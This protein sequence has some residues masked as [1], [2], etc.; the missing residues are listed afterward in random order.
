[1]LPEEIDVGSGKVLSAT[2]SLRPE[3]ADAA[4]NHWIL[5]GGEEW[6]LVIRDHYLAMKRWNR[7]RYGYADLADVTA[8]PKVQKNSCPGYWWSEQMKYYY[9]AFADCPRV[10]YR[11]LYLST[12]REY[13][14]WLTPRLTLTPPPRPPPPG[15]PPPAG[16]TSRRRG[17]LREQL[18]VRAAFDDPALV[19]H[20]DLV[21]IDDG[22]EAVGDD[23]RRAA[24]RD[25]VERL[26]DRRLGAAV[27]RAGRFVEDQDRRVLE[28]GAGD[29]DALL[30]A[31]R[32]LEPALAD[33]RFDSP[34]AG[35]R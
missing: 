11:Q 6:R 20:D 10:D 12:E 14:S 31:A 19:E 27:E 9:L 1:M 25:A 18:R 17:R 15:F 13:A 7:A 30:L 2:N 22:R 8:N 28:Q 32:K 4:F 29:R 26:L 21:G 3:L 5:D 35:R 34:R 23:D 16:T 33:Q 24:A